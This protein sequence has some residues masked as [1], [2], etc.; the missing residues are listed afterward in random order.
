MADIPNPEDETIVTSH[1]EQRLRRFKQVPI[2]ILVPNLITLLALC[3]G[4]TAIRLG[5]EG[6][7]ELAVGAVIL[8]IVLDAVDGRLARFLKGTSRFGA[9]LDSL[10]DFVNFGVA[11]AILIYLWSLNSLKSLGWL[12]ALCLAICCALR[13]ARF[14]VAID[15]PDKPAWMMNF[16]TGAPAP[17]GAG[18][19]MAPMYL[20]FLG[21]IPDG[22]EVAWAVLPYTAAVAL[23]MVS[24]VPTFSGKTLGSR[25][26]RDLVLPLLG[27][28]AL[29]VVSLITFPWEML[30]AMSLL[31]IALLPVGMRSYRRHK[32]D[33]ERRKAET[34]AA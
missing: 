10:A 24:R 32:A 13:L 34:P 8:A 12:V 20:G 30:T 1:R 11:P 3:S 27:V 14:N 21:I 29:V 22:H 7:Y 19:A 5:M 4:V 9:E 31:Y 26:S 6:R 16:F 18:L 33:Y 28:A 25:I 23:L 2:R 15:D 17:A